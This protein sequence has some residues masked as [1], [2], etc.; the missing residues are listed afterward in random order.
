M[1]MTVLSAPMAEPRFDDDDR[2]R[3]WYCVR[4]HLKHEHIAEAHL[5]QMV[6]AEVFNPRLRLLHH[7]RQGPRWFVESLFPNYVFARFVLETQLE[8]VIYTPAVKTVLRFGNRVAEI[9]EAVIEDLR[10]GLAVLDSEVLTD[11]PVEGDEVEIAGGAFAG[12]TASI[13]RVLPGKQRAQILVE[14]MGRL[15]PAELS[16]DLVLF[17]RRDAA[18]LAL[19]RDP[20][21]VRGRAGGSPFT[22]ASPLPR[23]K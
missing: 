10:R 16:L 13:T 1:E 9:P 21:G 20:T 2:E 6:G 11:A 14:I 15:V 19:P 3:A 12:M 8:K 23:A 4:T 17:N 22:L 18:Q 7:T 5:K